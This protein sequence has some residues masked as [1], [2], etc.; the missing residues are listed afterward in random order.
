MY[1][2]G[3]FELD[4]SQ[5]ELRRSGVPVHLEPQVFDLLAFLVHHR[6]RVV[7]KEEILQA[8]WGN[9]FVG[10]S[11][12][13][14][15]IKA[16]RRAVGDSGEG[17]RIIRTVRQRGYQFVGELIPEHDDQGHVAPVEPVRPEAGGA[18]GLEV[19]LHQQTAF[20]RSRDG[21]RIAYAT[22]GSGPPLVKAANWM[23]HLGHDLTSPVWGHWL[24]MLAAGHELVRYDERGCGLSEWQVPSFTF[25]DWVQDLELVVDSLGLTRFPLLGISQGAAVAVEYAVRHPDKVQRLVLIG[26]YAAGRSVRAAS[27]DD[28]RAA[29]LDLDLARVG[30]GRSDPA[31]RRVFA[32]QFFPEGPPETWDAFD[33][34]QRRTTSP[35][36]AVR[37]IESFAGIDIRRRAPLVRCPTLILHSRQDHR[38]PLACAQELVDLIPHA[39]LHA[40]PSVNHLLTET[41]PAWPILVDELSAFLE[42]G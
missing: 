13:T 17:Q 4:E 8:I 15:R 33:D 7:S 5:F 10:D 18:A 38:V 29:Q 36:N 21:S 40:L 24:A 28:R 41:E 39:R 23:T 27:D 20:C 14:T 12:I 42:E 2:F 37:F 25:D 6:D 11:A 26:G 19:R 9:R 32:M 1:R 22:L 31:F 30:W 34:L 35:E 16:A 3:D